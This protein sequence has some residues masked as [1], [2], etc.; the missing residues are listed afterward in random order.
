[1]Q[2][3][4]QTTARRGWTQQHSK[5]EDNDN[6]RWHAVNTGQVRVE[7]RGGFNRPVASITSYTSSVLGGDMTNGKKDEK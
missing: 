3:L 5:G 1:M 7:K 4:V 6:S 2:V